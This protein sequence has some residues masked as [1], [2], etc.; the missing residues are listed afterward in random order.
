MNLIIER[1]VSSKVDSKI[2]NEIVNRVQQK[3]GGYSI[4]IILEKVEE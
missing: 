3:I 1:N 2:I 4:R